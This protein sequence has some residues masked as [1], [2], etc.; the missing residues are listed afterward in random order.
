MSQHLTLAI[1]SATALIAGCTPTAESPATNPTPSPATTTP[2]DHAVAQAAA[3]KPSD[4]YTLRATDVLRIEM[5]QEQDFK[6]EAAVSQEGEITLPLIGTVAVAGRTVN[7]TQQLLTARY[8]E[9]F[10]EPN[11]TLLL[12]KYAERKVYIDGMVGRP[13]PVLFPPEERMTIGRAIAS[14]SGI[15]PRG[16]R[17]DVKLKRIVDG[18][19]VT[20]KI[21]MDEISSGKT[22]DI[23]LLENDYIFVRDSRI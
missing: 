9:Y 10:K 6:V 2:L 1:L 18:K 14:A 22:P 3:K 7:E 13:G 4:K 11:I 5:Y 19:E 20:I 8:R 17:S 16:E 12:I 15:L 23:E 21:D